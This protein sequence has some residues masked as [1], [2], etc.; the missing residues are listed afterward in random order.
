MSQIE[1]AATVVIVLSVSGS[2]DQIIRLVNQLKQTKC[3]II[4]ITGTENC[5]VAKLSDLNIAY[6]ITMHRNEDR[7]DFTSQIPAVCLIETLGRRI[8][9]RLVE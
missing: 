3:R 2:T 9:N 6:G 8:R 7:V 4:S 5:T 1:A